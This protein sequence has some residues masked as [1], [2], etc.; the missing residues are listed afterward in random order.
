MKTK[1]KKLKN[2]KAQIQGSL[3]MEKMVD[4]YEA[5]NTAED[6]LNKLVSLFS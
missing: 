2:P 3:L 1:S 6:E 5:Y 4:K